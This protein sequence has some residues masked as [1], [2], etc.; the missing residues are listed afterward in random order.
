MHKQLSTPRTAPQGL[1]VRR[2]QEWEDMRTQ[3]KNGRIHLGNPGRIAYSNGL[4]ATGTWCFDEIR[5]TYLGG[6]CT[7]VTTHQVVSR[8]TGVLIDL[9]NGSIVWGLSGPGSATYPDGSVFQGEWV[10]VENIGI[11]LD[12]GICQQT[13]EGHVY[14]GN[15]YVSG[16]NIFFGGIG[17]MISPDGVSYQGSWRLKRDGRK[18]DSIFDPDTS[19]LDTS[20]S[21]ALSRLPTGSFDDT[22][23]DL[24][25]FGDGA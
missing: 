1:V 13:E 17:T 22:I 25:V 23:A 8:G 18:I 5:G 4:V 9:P 24:D 10:L 7:T 20:F 19:F 6:A 12:C 21:E 2:I 14:S 3:V 16:R 15:R 11:A